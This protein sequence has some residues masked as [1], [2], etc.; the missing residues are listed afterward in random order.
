MHRDTRSCSRCGPDSR[1]RT[2]GSSACPRTSLP[3]VPRPSLLSLQLSGSNC[4]RRVAVLQLTRV[5]SS[6]LPLGLF[7][8]FLSSSP[9]QSFIQRISAISSR[10]LRPCLN[11]TNPGCLGAF[12]LRCSLALCDAQ[13]FLPFSFRSSQAAPSSQNRYITCTHHYPRKKWPLGQIDDDGERTDNDGSRR[14]KRRRTAERGRA[15]GEGA[16]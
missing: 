11:R 16:V 12:F 1:R 7:S 6:H 2:M 4:R 8:R 15:G 13:V 3:R 14:R 10:L 9:T 5:L